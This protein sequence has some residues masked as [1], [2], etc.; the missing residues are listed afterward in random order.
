MLLPLFKPAALSMW[1]AYM[2]LCSLAYWM[3]VSKR[4]AYKNGFTY[5][6]GIVGPKK[7]FE[8]NLLTLLHAW[9]VGLVL[10]VYMACAAVFLPL[11][12]V[13]G[14]FLVPAVFAIAFPVTAGCGSLLSSWGWLANSRAVRAH[15]KGPVCTMAH[16]DR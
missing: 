8:F 16:G 6:T 7:P 11:I 5:Y 9:M 1:P 15:L 13:F 12:V 10:L 2:P 4:A 14:V 3:V